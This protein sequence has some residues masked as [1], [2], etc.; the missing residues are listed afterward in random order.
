ML[1]NAEKMEIIE[2]AK[3]VI[4]KYS[5]SYPA[6][7]QVKI[8]ECPHIFFLG[9]V[10][11]RQIPFDKAFNIPHI[12]AKQIGYRFDDFASKSENFYVNFFETRKLHRFNTTMAKCFY[13][14]V[15]KIKYD[16]N[17]N[18]ENIWNDHP[19]SIELIKRLKTFKGVGTGIANMILNTLQ[20]RG[21][22]NTDKKGIDIC[23]DRNTLRVLQR[24]GLLK[25]ASQNEAIKIARDISPDYPGLLDKLFWE[26]GRVYCL[27]AI[28]KCNICKLEKYCIKVN[29][30]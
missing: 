13:S 26:T 29:Q 12:I 14:A 4:L 1:T 3:E 5:D 27:D 18:A 19:S 6:Y 30:I 2:L 11:D 7:M 20:R 8:D 15:Q 23:P 24:M 9:C 16:Y 17:S 28:R 10:M 25:K 22:I 21:F